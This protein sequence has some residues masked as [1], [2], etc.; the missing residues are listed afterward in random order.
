MA[1]I[2]RQPAAAP[3]TSADITNGIIVN[4]DIASNAAIS[5]TKISGLSAVATS[6]DYDDLTNKPTNLAT[7]GKAIAMTIVFGG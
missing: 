1:Y 3:L 5:T 2:G 4:D 7:T 6:N